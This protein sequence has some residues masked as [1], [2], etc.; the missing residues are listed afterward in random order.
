MITAKDAL[1]EDLHYELSPLD[2]VVPL[3]AAPSKI[4]SS[5]STPKSDV[6]VT[7]EVVDAVGV[8]MKPLVGKK[9]PGAQMIDTSNDETV[10]ELML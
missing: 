2:S 6:P 8:E 9:P 10:G 3:S 5:K 1:P 7:Q 4:D